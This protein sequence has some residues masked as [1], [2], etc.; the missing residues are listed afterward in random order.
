MY[1]MIMYWT[2]EYV[3]PFSPDII[4]NEPVFRQNE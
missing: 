3:I 1:N 4:R 2:V